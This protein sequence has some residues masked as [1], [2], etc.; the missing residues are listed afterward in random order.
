MRQKFPILFLGRLGLFK[1]KPVT[2]EIQKDAKP[3]SGRYYSIPKSKEEPLKKSTGSAKKRFW[4]NCV[5]MM[6]LLGHHPLLL[7]LII[8]QVQETEEDQSVQSQN[9]ARKTI[10]QG[11]QS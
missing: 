5:M 10:R 4:R 9:C 2:I 7:S 8:Q 6:T 1:I 3:Y 11:L